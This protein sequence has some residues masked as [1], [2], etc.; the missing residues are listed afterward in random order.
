MLEPQMPPVPMK[1]CLKIILVET[2][3]KVGSC[4]FCRL[5]T[6]MKS[7]Q[8]VLVMKKD[9]RGDKQKIGTPWIR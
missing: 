6:N 9:E 2:P 1:I 7:L 3:L 8:E 5:G 4:I